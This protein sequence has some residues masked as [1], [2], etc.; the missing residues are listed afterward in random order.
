MNAVPN[1]RKSTEFLDIDVDQLTGTLIFV[2]LRKPRRFEI[3]DAR[4][5]QLFEDFDDRRS[6]HRQ[7]YGDLPAEQATRTAQLADCAYELYRYLRGKSLRDRLPIN[8]RGLSAA[9]ESPQPLVNRFPAYGKAP[10]DFSDRLTA[11]D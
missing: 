8:Q 4:H 6:S 1:L 2:A 3:F 11:G 10:R 9:P 7:C 5:P